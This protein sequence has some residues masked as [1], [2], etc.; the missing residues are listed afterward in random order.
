MFLL[1]GC[2]IVKILWLIPVFLLPGMMEVSAG[3]FVVVW[4]SLQF[5]LCCS[6]R[7]RVCAETICGQIGTDEQIS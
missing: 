5:L 1:F 4:P 6:V 2:T 7:V 3:H